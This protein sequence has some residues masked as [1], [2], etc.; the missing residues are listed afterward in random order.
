MIVKKEIQAEDQFPILV[1]G[2]VSELENREVSSEEGMS[3]AKSKG[4]DGFIECSPR[5]GENVEETFEAL[6]RLMLTHSGMGI[7]Q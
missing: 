3:I 1:V 2:I 4:V 7:M 5:T 6:T